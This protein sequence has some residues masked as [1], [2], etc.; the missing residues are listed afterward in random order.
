MK[1][2]AWRII[3]NEINRLEYMLSQEIKRKRDEDVIF[4]YRLMIYALQSLYDF[5]SFPEHGHIAKK[6]AFRKIAYRK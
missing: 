3:R 2:R 6:H 1:K 4:A 5:G